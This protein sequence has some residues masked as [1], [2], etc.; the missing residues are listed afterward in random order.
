MT[1]DGSINPG[2]Q[3]FEEKG[4]KVVLDL[5]TSSV[6]GNLLIDYDDGPARG[7]RISSDRWRAHDC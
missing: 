3:V 4:V 7:F 6:S 2:D 5:Y 1:L